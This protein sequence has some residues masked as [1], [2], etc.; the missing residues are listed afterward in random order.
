M[1]TD[2]ARLRSLLEPERDVLEIDDIDRRILH[3]LHEDARASMRSIAAEVGMSAPAVAERIARME[4]GHVIRRHTIELDWAALGYPMLVVMP[5]RL[6]GD[7]DAATVLSALKAIDAMTEVIVL[8]AGYD[9][10][11]RFRVRDHADLQRLLVEEV[12]PIPGIDRVETMLAI[13]RLADPEPLQHV[14]ATETPARKRRR[15]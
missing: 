11:A 12:W 10:M 1:T 8:A 6:T 4:R 14:L 13:G 3:R 15:P 7:A 2:P 5:L 9:L